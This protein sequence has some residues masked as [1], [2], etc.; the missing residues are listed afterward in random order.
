MREKSRG[1][2]NKTARDKKEKRKKRTFL[3][4]T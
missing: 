4:H 1:K 3:F 2:K